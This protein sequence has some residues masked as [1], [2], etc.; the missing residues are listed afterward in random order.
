MAYLNAI[1]K[2]KVCAIMQP[3]YL[4]WMGY[5]DMIDKVDVFVFLDNVQLVRRS[6]QVRNRI[7]SI[8]GEEF[9]S[10]PIIHSPYGETL[11]NT[12]QFDENR[13]WKLAH[14]RKIENAYRKSP[15]FY[16]IMPW[17]ENTYSN[18]FPNLGS[19]NISVINSI[20]DIIGVK[21][22][23]IVCSSLGEFRETKDEKS[24]KI[25]KALD[26]PAYLS[27]LGAF[28]YI[29]EHNIGGAF[30]RNGIELYYHQYNH[31]VYDQINGNF[32]PYMGIVDLLFNV[33]FNN[34]LRTIRSGQV[35][36]KNYTEFAYNV[37]E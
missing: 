8:K 32:V 17:L 1:M 34:S 35:P 9:I 6:W 22:K 4:P 18:Y 26:C 3:T 28:D 11:I 14:L 23:R 25:C 20:C 24:V 2:Y 16:E 37:L 29:N 5:F 36:D 30:L 31:P 13:N 15:F 33:G 12:A 21:T 7:K 19:F 27:A 10:V